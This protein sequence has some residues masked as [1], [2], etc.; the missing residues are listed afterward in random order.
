MPSRLWLP[1]APAPRSC[2][3]EN[4]RAPAARRTRS[5]A[6][7]SA[8]P[9]VATVR[10]TDLPATATPDDVVALA[11]TTWRIA[12]PIEPAADREE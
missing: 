4:G 1:T 11:V 10:F 6:R 2:H 3:D 9:L 7:N 5:T 8:G 12:T